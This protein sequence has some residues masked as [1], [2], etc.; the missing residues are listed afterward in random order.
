MKQKKKKMVQL[1]DDSKFVFNF[2]MLQMAKIVDKDVNQDRVNALTVKDMAI[3]REIVRKVDGTVVVDM[4]EEIVVEETIT[5][6]V[7]EEE[8][9][10]IIVIVV[11]VV[12]VEVVE[13]MAVEII[14]IM[15]MVLLMEGNLVHQDEQEKIV[16]EVLHMVLQEEEVLNVL[17]E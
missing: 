1:L 12:I 3:G 8:I 7:M 11:I 15:I 2:H 17:L 4:T 16:E 9:V 6:E 5:A 10:I 13:V 14:I